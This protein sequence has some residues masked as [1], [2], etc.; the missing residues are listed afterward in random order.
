MPCFI[1]VLIAFWA[2]VSRHPRTNEGYT[3]DVD[4]SELRNSTSY[5]SVLPG[6]VTSP[7]MMLFL[8]PGLQAK[9]L[10]G[11][12]SPT[13]NEKQTRKAASVSLGGLRSV[14]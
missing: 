2:H 7:S 3:C 6:P 13:S 5:S 1:D 9:H 12:G 10:V 4:G 11:A 8:I 14:G